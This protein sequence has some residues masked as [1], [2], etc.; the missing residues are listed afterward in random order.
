MT[1]LKVS[2]AG[3]DLNELKRLVSE[4][5][6][7]QRELNEFKVERYDLFEALRELE[8]AEASANAAIKEK[9]KEIAAKK[10]LTKSGFKKLLSHDGLAVEVQIRRLREIKVQKLREM[11]DAA[12]NWP[13][14]FAV[15]LGEFD[16]AC[17]A[18]V[19]SDNVQK[20]VINYKDPSYVVKV[21]SEDSEE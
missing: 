19:I 2:K 13:K 4:Y 6:K 15:S 11:C 8:R 10:R 1:K 21:Y 18:G 5:R 16:K 3:R 7:R 20:K 14:L 12:D 17:Q 9:V